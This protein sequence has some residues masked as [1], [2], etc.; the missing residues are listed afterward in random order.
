MLLRSSPSSRRFPAACT[1]LCRSAEGL[2][3]DPVKLVGGIGIV[4][5]GLLDLSFVY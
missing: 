2:I 4:I 3:S 1:I 5:A